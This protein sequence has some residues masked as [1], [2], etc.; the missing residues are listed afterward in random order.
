MPVEVTEPMGMETMVYFLVDGTE[1]CARVAPTAAKDPG[2][3]MRFMADMR[4]M[5]LIDP[6]TDRVVEAPATGSAEMPA[7]SL[8]RAV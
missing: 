4:H 2:E 5:H 1:M 3:T 8:G 7:A 6:A